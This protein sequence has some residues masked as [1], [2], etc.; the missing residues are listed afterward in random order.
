MPSSLSETGQRNERNLD[1]L[2]NVPRLLAKTIE[3]LSPPGYQAQLF[4]L[5]NVIR[6]GRTLIEEERNLA[7]FV[8]AAVGIV[9]DGKKLA[10]AVR[11]ADFVLPDNCAT[12]DLIISTLTASAHRDLFHTWLKRHQGIRGFDSEEKVINTLAQA[13]VNRAAASLL[14]WWLSSLYANG[15]TEPFNLEELL[16]QAVL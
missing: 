4:H 1:W 12:E 6:P 8:Y 5:L 15:F 14:G 2:H 11:K 16:T 3:C 9:G 10:E 13:V 7:S